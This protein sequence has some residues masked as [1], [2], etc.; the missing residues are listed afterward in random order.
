M[1]GFI[2]MICWE[3]ISIVFESRMPYGGWICNKVVDLISV[4][5]NV[6]N[7]AFIHSCLH[8]KK[9]LHHASGL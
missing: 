5:F 1:L 9:K 8:M 7:A 6:Y 3:S 4:C 2:H